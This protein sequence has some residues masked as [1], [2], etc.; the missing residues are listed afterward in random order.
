M[1]LKKIYSYIKGKYHQDF[2]LTWSKLLRNKIILK[3]KRKEY[4]KM[5]A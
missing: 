2:D 5:I 3:M 1:F 4:N